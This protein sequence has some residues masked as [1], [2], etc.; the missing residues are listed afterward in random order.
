MKLDIV[1]AVPGMPFDGNTL[2]TKS[3][4][5]SESAGYYMA[6]AL[7]KLGHRIH[8]FSNVAEF[9]E[10][11]GVVYAPFARWNEFARA[12]ASDVH[13][14][15]RAPEL[16]PL[17]IQTKLN[18][19]WCHD[20]A[21]KR[22]VDLFRSVKWTT[23]KI[24][25]LSQF[26]KAQYQEVHGLTDQEIYVSRNGF[27]FSMQPKLRGLNERDPDL[28]IYCA[29]PERG[30]D[31]LV[32]V[33]APQ[34]LK[35]RPTAKFVLCTYDNKVSELQS[36]IAGIADRA[37]AARL[38]IQD[39]GSLTKGQLYELMSNA[40]AYLY[41]TPSEVGSEFRE[42]SCIAALEAQACGLPFFH[43]GWGALNETV[44]SKV[45]T[46][47]TVADMGRQAARLVLDPQR[48]AQVQIAGRAHVQHF[49]W[50][51][52]AREW[53][54]MFLEE[55]DRNNECPYRL[56]RWFYKR[57]EIE[58]AELALDM[59]DPEGPLEPHA[60]LL[61]K[62]IEEHY[63]F[64]ANQEALAGHYEA[65]GVDTLRDLST[66]DQHFTREYILG[67]PE[68][69]F[70]YIGQ[71]IRDHRARRDEEAKKEYDA[72]PLA[73][74]MPMPEPFKPAPYV[75]L[76]W[77]CGH[78]WSSLYYAGNL[79]VG[80]DGLDV[81]PG[82]CEWAK[83]LL[84][85]KFDNKLNCRFTTS[86]D[87]LR[88]WALGGR[89][90]AVVISEVLEHVL[91]PV[92]TLQQAEAM[93]KPGGLVILTVPF[94]P[95]EYNGPN[96]HGY[97]AHI[98]EI[99]T[100]DLHDMIGHKPKLNLAAQQQTSHEAL[101]EACG[102]TLAFYLADHSPIR[103][104]DMTRKLRIQRPTQTVSV[105]MIAHSEADQTLRWAL[106]GYKHVADEIVV[107]NDGTMTPAGIQA[108]VDAGARIINVPNPMKEGFS[109]ARN[110]V[111]DESVMD[112]VLWADSDERLMEPQE[113]RK[114]L[115]QNAMNGYTIKQ[116]HMA[117][118][119]SID[120]DT[121]VRLIRR[122]SGARFF[123]L[124]HEHPELEMN[125]GPGM[126]CI[127]GG[128]P[129]LWHVGYSSHTVRARRFF[130]NRPLLER[131]RKENPGRV[132]GMFLDARDQILMMQEII[133][134]ANLGRAPHDER[135]L[136]IP[137]E[138]RECARVCIELCNQYW[139]A[140]VPLAGISLDQFYWE[141]LR[142][143]GRGFDAHIDVRLRRDGVGDPGD[144][145][146]RFA[147]EEDLNRFLKKVVA[148]K[149]GKLTGPYW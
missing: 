84:K 79:G 40:A 109:A 54:E 4:G 70:A 3:L 149:V 27:D 45:P 24:I 61:K 102:F 127:L 121:P 96:W 66:K 101:A 15:Q 92:A 5:G 128:N 145:R 1:L 9:S 28:F 134:R 34:L 106:E 23:D 113:L 81:D 7:A 93:V 147:D 59:V 95:W 125:K 88:G 52:I 64:R 132:L 89:Y 10:S 6:R 72:R 55:I 11:D 20:L 117:A 107:G 8:V 29:R 35:H 41:P 87:E 21:L 75:V 124:I 108:C 148:D 130:R 62:E 83:H 30:L 142:I 63:S 33:V 138:A 111:L 141:A 122:S 50:D 126:V 14:I 53:S 120:A 73:F 103:A 71:A 90:D 146:M 80:V 57:S 37:K 119:A 22:S 58:G 136:V 100:A 48:Y 97:R 65:M 43:T 19:L 118:D 76:D 114:F 131:D 112:F 86:E 137:D 26:H 68:A 78:G 67:N 105:N 139:A 44:Q 42:I 129:V 133:G 98:R 32:D 135:P 17:N 47:A 85:D 82:A 38:P 115:R 13:I 94:G 56:A 140:N 144:L 25:L 99:S 12:T 74:G 31:N 46:I 49:D 60:A 51:T 39:V 18:V 123:G 91:D 36:W 116:V 104:R 2:K 110:A 16:V 77:G 69:R 143:L